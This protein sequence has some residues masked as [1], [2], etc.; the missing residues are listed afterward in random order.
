MQKGFWRLVVFCLILAIV[1]WLHSSG[2]GYDILDFFDDPSS[3]VPGQVDL[4]GG[5]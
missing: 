1:Y 5:D 2:V 4:P 3:V